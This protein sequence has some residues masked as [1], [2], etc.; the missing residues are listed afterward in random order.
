VIR[1]RLFDFLDDAVSPVAIKELRQAVRGRFVVATLILSLLAQTVTMFITMINQK[2]DALPL[3]HS[4]VGRL[5]FFP[6]FGVL[7]TACIFFVPMYCGLRMMAERSDSN[8]DLLFI[9]TIKPRSIML[10]K[11]LAATALVGL[12]FSASMPFLIFCY[13]LR[14]IDFVAVL[15]LAAIAFFLIISQSILALF[16]GALPASK[17]FKLLL[18]IVVLVITFVMY[19]PMMAM[20]AD[21]TRGGAASF[22]TRAEFRNTALSIGS[23]ILTMD[24]IFLV[25]ATALITPA[26]AN[27]A[28]PMRTLLA[29]LWTVSGA[30]I[31][32]A[33]FVVV[34]V[35]AITMWAVVWLAFIWLVLMSAIGE[36][37]EWGP[38]VARTIP[39][40]FIARRIAFLFYSGPG[41]ILWAL[42]FMA[43]TVAAVAGAARLLPD[44]SSYPVPIRLTWMIDGCFG[45]T[46]Y[47][48]TALFIRRRWL[49]RRVPPRNTWAIALVLFLFG[50]IVPP[51]IFFVIYN[52]T[53]T[54][55]DYF[56]LAMMGNPFPMTSRSRVFLSR[57]L[58]LGVWAGVSTLANARWLAD[59]FAH[60]RRGGAAAA[61]A[62]G[63]PGEAPGAPLELAR[64]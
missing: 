64:E 9:T 47:A 3:E 16:V 39:T 2:L 59:R 49:A 33:T 15:M 21:I 22:F 23:F 1:R 42:L 12:L 60:F 58:F 44:P 38:R 54:F 17:P 62:A 28:R 57:T 27:R 8:V 32:C 13:V 51:I 19:A 10:G 48:M 43:A 55:N 14:G 46:A 52:E 7:F 63:S 35:D 40:S 24:A 61:S 5:A 18:G 30:V 34:D 45:I 29:T 50:A 20:V 37:E 25:A 41:G 11:L 56:H 36:R 26:T 4:P 31:A 6:L 53:Q